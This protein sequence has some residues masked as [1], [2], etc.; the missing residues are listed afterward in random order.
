MH[1]ASYRTSLVNRRRSPWCFVNSKISLS[2]E[3]LNYN[4]NSDV[5]IAIAYHWWLRLLRELLNSVEQL[6]L[7]F[8]FLC[9]VL[10]LVDVP[11]GQEL[12]QPL[13]PRS[14]GGH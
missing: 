7:D 6:S 11:V 4:F 5:A 1:I 14:G 3:N 12:V 9:R 13:E 10:F 8:C 2:S